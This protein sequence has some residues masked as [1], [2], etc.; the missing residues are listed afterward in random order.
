MKWINLH[1]FPN[2]NIFK[3]LTILSKLLNFQFTQHRTKRTSTRCIEQSDETALKRS[4]STP[5]WYPQQ[6]HNSSINQSR[7]NAFSTQS[8][9]PRKRTTQVSTSPDGT[10]SSRQKVFQSCPSRKEKAEN[11]RRGETGKK[12]KTTKRRTGSVEKRKRCECGVWRAFVG[13]D[14][15]SQGH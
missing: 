2:N 13:R 14:L 11:P 1:A 5:S 12:K 4:L 3:Q 15:N 7:R 10:C 6:A 8:L 9:Y